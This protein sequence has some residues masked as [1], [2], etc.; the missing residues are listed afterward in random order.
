VSIFELTE[1]QL[2]AAVVAWLT[3][4]GWVVYQEVLVSGGSADIVASQGRLLWAIECKTSLSLKVIEQAH[5]WL[6]LAHY[7]SVATPPTRAHFGERVCRDYGIGTLRVVTNH[8]P[9]CEVAEIVAPRLQR[10]I[11]DR[12]RDKLCEE[13]K[14]FAAAGSTAGPRWSP[15][16]R[17]A[18]RLRDVVMQRP[19]I[20]F[21]QLIAEVPHH[22]GSVASARSCLRHW[23][24]QGVIEGIE[25][26]LD[27]GKLLAYP[28]GYRTQLEMSH[29]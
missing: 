2:G 20:A 7:V 16:Q 19:G 27:R 24:A 23:I 8:P 4:Q 6:G 1:A 12:L 14:T 26:R 29:G 22:Y 15:F 13:Q 21:Q 5:R 28:S 3:D 17:T 25:L 11:G 9:L 10:R 18:S